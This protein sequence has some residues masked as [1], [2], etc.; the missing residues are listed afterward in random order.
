MKFPK[1]KIKADSMYRYLIVAVVALLVA[2]LAIVSMNIVK[3]QSDGFLEG[4]EVSEPSDYFG[5]FDSKYMQFKNDNFRLAVI[6]DTETTE[7]LENEDEI[8]S[9]LIEVKERELSIKNELV[10]NDFEMVMKIPEN[11]DKLAIRFISEAYYAAGNVGAVEDEENGGYITE[12]AG[13]NSGCILG[14]A[15]PDGTF[16]RLKT[17]SRI[18]NT[19]VFD[20]KKSE[21]TVNGEETR[22]FTLDGDELKIRTFLDSNFH[23]G[24]SVGKDDDTIITKDSDIICRKLK[25]INGVTPA[26]IAFAFDVSD[27]VSEKEPAVFE[28]VSID[29]KVSDEQSRYKQTFEVNEYGELIKDNVYPIVTL[30]DSYYSKR[31]DGK[32]EVN[33]IVNSKQTLRSYVYSI[34]GNITEDD[35]ALECDSSAV[36]HNKEEESM[37]RTI[38]IMERGTYTFDFKGWDDSVYGSVKINAKYLEE[39]DKAPEYYNDEQALYSFTVAL[40]N[41]VVDPIKGTHCPLGKNVNVPSMKD[42]VYDDFSSYE[43]LT[44]KVYF[45]NTETSGVKNTAYVETLKVGNYSFFLDFTD[46]AGNDMGYSQTNLPLADYV[47]KFSIE[48]DAVP[49]VLGQKEQKIGVVGQRYFAYRFKVDAFGCDIKYTLWYNPDLDA[50][51]D[52]DGW[53][54]IPS[55]TGINRGYKGDYTFEE[56]RAIDYNGELNFTPDKIGAYMIKC[57]ATSTQSVTNNGGDFVIVRVE[58]EGL[59]SQ[60]VDMVKVNLWSYIF[61]A[62]GVFT[63]CCSISF[64]VLAVHKQKLRAA[65]SSVSVENESGKEDNLNK[66]E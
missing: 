53:V 50:T 31:Q 34:L 3:E 32:V 4:G 61:L 37:T 2:V 20:F 11:L 13:V 47:F 51:K 64:Y 30:R 48:D 1:L 66:T 17:Y 7:E 24:I 55:F 44:Y 62:I 25:S 49:E 26:E 5:G 58:K 40:N 46:E 12:A 35:V 52:S 54:E 23:M 38:M 65:S 56:L 57:D 10:I 8:Y 33:L 39:D 6:G 27:K 28:I 19:V 22:N 45:T 42:L 14:T 43:S 63:M 41:A 21:V 18:A 29:Q 16:Y 60:L 9:E 15:A 36:W 59:I